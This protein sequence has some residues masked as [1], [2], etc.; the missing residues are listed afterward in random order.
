MRN[1]KASSLSN[2][3][4]IISTQTDIVLK[5]NSS[6]ENLNN[7]FN[8]IQ[9]EITSSQTQNELAN[10]DIVFAEMKKIEKKN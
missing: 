5:T 3:N 7:E 8:Q 10:S 1:Y 4:F 2:Q 9:N 6:N